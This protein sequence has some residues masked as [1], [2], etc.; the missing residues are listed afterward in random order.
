MTKQCQT[1]RVVS[2]ETL[3]LF[4]EIQFVEVEVTADW[5]GHGYF[6]S[7]PDLVR[8][9]NDDLELATPDHGTFYTPGEKGYTD[10]PKAD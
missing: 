6:I 3:A 2:Q 8:R 9:M 5:L 1:V 10:Y 7:N 4:P